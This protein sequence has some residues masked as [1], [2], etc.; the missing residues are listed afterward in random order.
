MP[1]KRSIR[2][3]KRS[4]VGQKADELEPTSERNPSDSSAEI[5]R[6]PTSDQRLQV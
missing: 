2:T 3:K 6:E 5:F 1:R 4:R